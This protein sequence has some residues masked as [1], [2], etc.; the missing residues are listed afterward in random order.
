MFHNICFRK[1]FTL[2]KAHGRGIEWVMDLDFRFRAG[3]TILGGVR[4]V[5]MRKSESGYP[6]K[7]LL[8]VLT[9]QEYG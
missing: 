3:I 4:G 8:L 2:P 5:L 6:I 9:L 7:Q 1:F